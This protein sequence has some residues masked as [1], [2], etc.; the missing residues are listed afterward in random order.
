VRDSLALCDIHF[1]ARLS[2]KLET[3]NLPVEIETITPDGITY[4]DTVNFPTYVPG[5]S[6][7][8]A[9]IQKEGMWR[10]VVSSYRSSVRFPEEGVWLFRL[11]PLFEDKNKASWVKEMGVVVLPSDNGN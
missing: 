2:Y 3:K 4:M 8:R 9:K 10:D 1:Y 6:E 5:A 7:Q 11:T